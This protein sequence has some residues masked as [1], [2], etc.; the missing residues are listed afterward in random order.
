MNLTNDINKN[1][2]IIKKELNIGKSF[3][4][5]ERVIDVHK[6]K[7]YMFY[8]DGFI[9]DTNLEYVRRDMYNLKQ[10]DFDT[11]HSANDLIEKALSSI[12][13]STESD[14]NNIIKFILSGQTALLG[15]NFKEAVILDFRTYPSRGVE[16][17]SKEKVLRG[18][19]DGF[20]ETLVSN[21][22]LIRRRVKDPN[23]TFKM[24]TIGSISKT[25]LVLGYL[26]TKVKKDSLK[27]I[28]KLIED[29][30]IKSLTLGEQS[31]IEVISS[32]SNI[33]PFP[34]V[35]Y[36]ERPDVAA[37]QLIEGSIIILI[38]NTPSAL[39]IPSNIFDFMQSIDDY[40]MPVFTG[41]YLKLIRNLVLLLNLFL[42]PIYVL[43]SDNPNWFNGSLKF[44]LPTEAYI[45]PLFL[46]FFIAEL[47]IDG[48]KLASLNTPDS[49]GT[50]L[51]I[52]GG[53]IL[54]DYA[55][56]TGWF[57][58]HTILYSAIIALAS[59]VQ[60]SIELSFALKF[61]RIILLLLTGFFG[62][63]GF[64]IGI[65]I[66]FIIL[67]S[68]KSLTGEPY[69]YPLFPFNWNAL[70]HLLFRCEKEISKK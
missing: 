19:H 61:I 48:L 27:K 49:L 52:I 47:A 10:D 63:Y 45:I 70:K 32:K 56:D 38:D 6:N 20:V 25:D 17:P 69:L 28:E 58:P 41:N 37:A 67:A 64:I 14:I 36:T 13:A 57:T 24:Y 5:I 9:K 51:S 44:L 40:Y 29:L 35:R 15:P 54:G 68:T 66:N 30:K 53:L 2:A 42:T 50:S 3:D 18:S 12:E 1:L 59:F 8:L 16:E 11:I 22:A 62:I 39:I 4:V 21:T 55:V 33:N 34:K 7:F 26:N 65:I 46:Q 31:L 60:P 43:L 23:L